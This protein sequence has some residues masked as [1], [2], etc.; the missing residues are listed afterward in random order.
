MMTMTVT[1]LTAILRLKM[2]HTTS[3][4]DADDTETT[5]ESWVH[6][7][8]RCTHDAE[9]GVK[10]LKLDD[11]ISMQRTRKWSWAQKLA[12]TDEFDWTTAVLR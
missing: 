3:S 7:I 11:W 10:K 12:L 2:P 1:K 9:Q 4:Q 5:L 8:K 6:W